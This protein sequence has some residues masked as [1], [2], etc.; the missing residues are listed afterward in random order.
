MSYKK[1]YDIERK[2]W[3]NLRRDFNIDVASKALYPPGFQNT[4]IDIYHIRRSSRD[5]P[6]NSQEQLRLP[7]SEE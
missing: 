6:H 7:S 5:D 2:F 4:D 3:I 1:R